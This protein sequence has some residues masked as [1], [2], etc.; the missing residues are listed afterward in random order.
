[1]GPVGLSDEPFPGY[2]NGLVGPVV[3]CVYVCVCGCMRVRVCVYLS[4][5]TFKQTCETLFALFLTFLSFYS[6]HADKDYGTCWSTTVLVLYPTAV[7]ASKK[8]T[9]CQLLMRS[10]AYMILKRKEETH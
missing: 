2:L 8:T 7:P 10:L 4:V 1:M 3:E 6:G 9:V 5:C